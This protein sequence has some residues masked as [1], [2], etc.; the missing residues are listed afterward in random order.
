MLLTDFELPISSQKKINFLD[1]SVI[2]DLELEETKDHKSIY[3]YVFEPKT[4]LGKNNLKL[5]STTY[6][7]DKKFI[8]DSKKLISN[9]N[10]FIQPEDISFN[11]IIEIYDKINSNENFNKDYSFIEFEY[12]SHLNK[13]EIVLQILSLYNISS[14]LLSLVTP[15]VMLIIPFLIIKVQG[16]PITLE[17]YIEFLKLSFKN[18]PLGNFSLD[19]GKIAPEKKIYIILSIIFYFYEGIDLVWNYDLYT[20]KIKKN[21]SIEQYTT[22]L[23]KAKSSY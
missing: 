10:T 7:Y 9:L 6:T 20:G 8:N 5:W 22:K 18:H 21:Q 1:N 13:N 15:I 11:E 2:N 4:I 17:K 19:F 23:I 3:E 16:I 12:L 14:P